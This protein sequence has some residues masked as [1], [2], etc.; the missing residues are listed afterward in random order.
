[1][2][3]VFLACIGYFWFILPRSCLFQ[4]VAVCYALFHILYKKLKARKKMK[5]LKKVKQR[6]A[7]K[8]ES[9]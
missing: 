9:T 8:N 7:N 4:R 2:A 5:T 1:M 6:K 3:G